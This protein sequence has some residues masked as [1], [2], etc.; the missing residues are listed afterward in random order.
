MIILFG[1]P[2][3]PPFVSLWTPWDHK[4]RDIELR[5][6]D[7]VTR[8]LRAIID[9]DNFIPQIMSSL[10]TLLYADKR[11]RQT[12]NLKCGDKIQ[13]DVNVLSKMNN[14]FTSKFAPLITEFIKFRLQQLMKD[15][16]CRILNNLLVNKNVPVLKTMVPT[17]TI[18][19]KNLSFLKNTKHQAAK[20][21]TQLVF[22]KHV[23]NFP[24]LKERSTKH[25]AI[26]VSLLHR[27]L[28]STS[29]TLREAKGSI[30][31]KQHPMRR[32]WP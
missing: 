26:I 7:N 9:N 8:D 27:N 11:R 28:A 12:P 4:Q 17:K 25:Y 3:F 2:K 6:P 21:C 24:D 15:H 5:T 31:N 22:F 13:V 1:K 14:S 30:C 18:F 20:F 29:G 23:S 32:P 16:R 10:Q 19:L